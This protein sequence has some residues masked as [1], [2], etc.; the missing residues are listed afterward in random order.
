MKRFK[1]KFVDSDGDRF[2]VGPNAPVGHV[3][4]GLEE[5]YFSIYQGENSNSGVCLTKAQ[6]LELAAALLEAYS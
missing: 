2:Y 1:L 4:E 5:T 3:D 6:A